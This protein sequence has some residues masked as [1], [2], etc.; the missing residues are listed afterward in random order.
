MILSH[1]FPSGLKMWLDSFPYR[2][3]WIFIGYEIWVGA[4]IGYACT[5]D[6]VMGVYREIMEKRGKVFEGAK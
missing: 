1:T 5:P 4:Y 3:G 2:D 6:M